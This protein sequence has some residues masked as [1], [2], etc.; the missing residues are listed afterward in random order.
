MTGGSGGYEWTFRRVVAAIITGVV[1]AAVIV[2]L[3]VDLLSDGNIDG[4]TETVWTLDSDYVESS[5]QADTADKIGAR[6]GQL[7][8]GCPTSISGDT[9]STFECSVA[10]RQRNQLTASVTIGKD[11]AFSW[12]IY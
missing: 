10:D 7:K 5:I 8:I 2:A 9:G 6:P 1:G 11:G 3:G 12:V 4:N